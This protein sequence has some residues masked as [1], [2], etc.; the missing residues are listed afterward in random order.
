[1]MA[2]KADRMKISRFI[3]LDGMDGVLW[4]MIV[5]GFSPILILFDEQK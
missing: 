4:M 2:N 3:K 5:I 1:M